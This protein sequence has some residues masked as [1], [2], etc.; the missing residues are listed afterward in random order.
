MNFIGENNQ[1]KLDNIYN[2]FI[3]T[4]VNFGV[5]SLVLF[6]FLTI[7]FIYFISKLEKQAFISELTD[8]IEN[9]MHS[10]NIPFKVPDYININTLINLYSKPDQ[11]TEMYNKLLMNA[12]VLV[13][14]ILWVALIIII[15][16]VKWYNWN[17][18]ELS[19]I[20]IENILIFM[21]I[22]VIEYLFF[23]RIAFKY[24][25]VEPSFM[26]K[27]LIQTIQK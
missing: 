25:P 12:L 16:I 6:T 1:E 24:I 14:I 11:T 19:I 9:A 17:E 2:F 23:T 4:S 22:G 18:L 8:L 21:V 15:F 20:I 26:K 3:N 7:F 5:H 10:L 27:Q 13:N